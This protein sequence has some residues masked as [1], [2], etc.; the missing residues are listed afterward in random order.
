MDSASTMDLN[1]QAC[2]RAIRARDQRFD[3]RLFVGVRTTG[4]YCRPIC[5]ARTPKLCNVVFYATAAAAQEGGFRPCLRC[6]PESSPDLAAWRG[7]SNTVSRALA[8]ITDGALDEGGVDA[9]AERLGLGERQ[10]RRLFEKHLGASPIA[11]A[12]TRRVLFA[13]QL[14]HQT[15][16]KMADVA[17]AAG[18]GSIR[19]FNDTFHRMYQ[20]PP[21]TLRRHLFSGGDAGDDVT[22]IRLL[23]PYAPPYDW[24]A[25][26][27]FL[28]ARAIAGVE[29]V[30]ADRY[31]RT[32]ELD[33]RRGTI[34][35][36]P[37]AQ[38]DALA[39]TIRFPSV[40]ALPAIVE[41][42]RRVFDLGAD[43]ATIASALSKDRRLAP[44]VAARPGLRV[45][46]AWDGFEQGVRAIL[47]QQITVKAARRLVA[48]LVA[49]TGEPIGSAGGG[50]D[51]LR[52]L[53]P[54]PERVSSTD[55]AGLG[56]PRARAA[57]VAA[58]AAAA[59]QDPRLFQRDQSLDAAVA[60]LCSLPGIGEWTAQY[61][62]M[63]VL[64]EPDAFPAA[65]I[66][67]LRSMSRIT[68]VETTP[69]VAGLC[70]PVPVDRRG[71]GRRAC[72][73]AAQGRRMRA[74]ASFVAGR[75]QS[76]IGEIVTVCDQEER[77][78]ALDF[79][80]YEDRM[81]RLLRRQY[82]TAAGTVRSGPVPRT[83]VNA[84]D[85]YF[86]GDLEAIASLDVRTAGTAFQQQVWSELRRIPAG[87]TS[88]YGDL[89]R[90]IDRPRACRAVGLANGANPVG[91]VVPCHRVIGADGQLTGY[92]G[93]LA[94]KRWLLAHE[95][96][97]D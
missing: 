49:A 36:R 21:S 75:V 61:M 51:G 89:A 60:R 71:D 50:V 47:G 31:C 2:Y 9:M 84:L 65:D 64:R 79:H 55:V 88:T 38:R 12:Q 74:M 10:L 3:G 44:I 25:M 96:A 67:L 87:R 92:G 45:P 46:G 48:G 23:L 32:I 4:I 5:P 81:G 39:A 52:L 76:P 14:I 1:R 40:K 34:E 80:D 29:V 30:E 27:D 35:V 77:L 93:G 91:I 62:A 86:A 19:R 13:K 43:V 66:G 54:R 69:A 63:R 90:T 24:N 72:R 18:F 11:V 59:A 20:R 26:I 82:G 97:I 95:H 94:R 70:R 53:F 78:R 16:M 41:R 17:L 68:G 73:Y 28:A 8:L 6:R 42:I 37:A 15:S 83:I 22:G 33:G 7:T 56:V 57:A 85:A 58:L